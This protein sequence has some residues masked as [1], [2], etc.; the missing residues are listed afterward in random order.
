MSN[1]A[2]QPASTQFNV[3][4]GDSESVGFMI[5]SQGLYRQLYLPWSS[6]EHPCWI[7]SLENIQYVNTYAIN[8]TRPATLNSLYFH[9]SHLQTRVTKE[10][11][12]Q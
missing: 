3:S 8:K 11:K 5:S 6:R 10:K 1:L 9:G 7:K 12:R 4:W 2:W